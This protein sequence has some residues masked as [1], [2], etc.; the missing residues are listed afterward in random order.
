MNFK[1]KAVALRTEPPILTMQ[2]LT[3]A[4]DRERAAVEASARAYAPP[5]IRNAQA[6]EAVIVQ[7]KSFSELITKELDDM[8]AAAK[9]EIAELEAECQATR[10]DYVRHTTRISKDIKRLEDGVR[11]SIETVRLLHEQVRKLDEP[12]PQQSTTEAPTTRTQD[13]G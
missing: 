13:A 3:E 2:H 7:V 1:P 8:I 9:A 10:D 5:A 4:A 6:G 12:L 11:L